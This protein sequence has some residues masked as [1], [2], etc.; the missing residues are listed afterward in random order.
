MQAHQKTAQTH[1][2]VT[3]RRLVAGGRLPAQHRERLRAPVAARPARV[4]RR[5]GA[6]VAAVQREPVADRHGIR[7]ELHAEQRHDDHRLAAAVA[8]D[9]LQVAEGGVEPLLGQGEVARVLEHAGEEAV[10][11]G[12]RAFTAGRRR[13]HALRLEPRIEMTGGDERVRRGQV[14]GQP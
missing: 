14:A 10:E 11:R 13:V 7:G 2:R 5:L 3:E 8:D 6:G 4:V 1:A 12:V 9:P